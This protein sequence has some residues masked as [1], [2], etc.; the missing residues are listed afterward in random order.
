MVIATTDLPSALEMVLLGY[1]VLGV[2]AIHE[3]RDDLMPYLGSKPYGALTLAIGLY[4]AHLLDWLNRIT[5]SDFVT[6]MGAWL[7]IAVLSHIIM[8]HYAKD[9]TDLIF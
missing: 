7:G 2:F 3:N 8:T 1:V 4:S 9:Q 6:I 5:E